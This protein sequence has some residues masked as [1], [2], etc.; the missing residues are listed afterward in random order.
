MRKRRI[1]FDAVNEGE[2]STTRSTGPTM[3]PL[4]YR[5]HFKM[6]WSARLLPAL[7]YRKDSKVYFQRF[8]WQRDRLT[9]GLTDQRT[10]R[11]SHRDRR[12]RITNRWLNWRTN[13]RTDGQTDAVCVHR[14]SYHYS[15]ATRVIYNLIEIVDF[16][17]SWKEV[18]FCRGKRKSVIPISPSSNIYI[19]RERDGSL[20][21]T[22]AL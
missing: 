21:Y 15:D 6:A 16:I 3:R 22:L 19:S 20:L 13:G 12:M 5:N 7:I 1:Y 8:S 4:V 18:E 11:P 14:P 2:K 17:E 9:D 10:N